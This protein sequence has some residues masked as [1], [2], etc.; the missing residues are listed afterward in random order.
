MIGLIFGVSGIWLNH[1]AVLKL[2]VAQQ[3]T[4]TQIALPD[5]MPA[6]PE[7]MG[8][9]LQQTLNIQ[10]PANRIR[11]EK[12][13]PVAWAERPAKGRAARKARKVQGTAL[14]RPKATPRATP[15]S[16]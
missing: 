5:P 15:P 12:A 4:N 9:W 11:V 16:R 2:P 7:A 13:K 1:R 3:R 10:E 6:T 8:A 14:P